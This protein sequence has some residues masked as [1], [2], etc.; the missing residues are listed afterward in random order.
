MVTVDCIKRLIARWQADFEMRAFGKGEQ[1]IQTYVADCTGCCETNEQ[2][3]GA[4]ASF[5]VSQAGCRFKP[6]WIDFFALLKEHAEAREKEKVVQAQAHEHQQWE[7]Y[8]Q[9]PKGELELKLSQNRAQEVLDR[10]CHRLGIKHREVKS[11]LK[12]EGEDA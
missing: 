3:E 12:E 7:E 9:T 6:K 11:P 8:W 1:D 10:L 5:R 2:V 4:Y